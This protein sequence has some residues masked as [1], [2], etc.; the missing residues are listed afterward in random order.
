MICPCLSQILGFE[1]GSVFCASERQFTFEEAGDVP[2]LMHFS[3]DKS[4]T[5][6]IDISS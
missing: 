1:E 2:L 6:V 3:L 4:Y 5:F